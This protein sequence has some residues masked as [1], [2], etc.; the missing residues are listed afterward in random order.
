MTKK[1]TLL[2]ISL[3][4]VFIISG[5]G[6]NTRVLTCSGVTPGTNM[7]AVSNYEAIFKNNELSIIKSKVVFKDIT[8]DNLSSVWD[9]FKTQFNDQ[10]K[11]VEEAGF[12]RTTEADDKNYTFTVNIEIDFD[13]ISKETMKKYD[14]TDYGSKTYD[15]IKKEITSDGVTSCK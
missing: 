2:I 5:C 6:N 3:F 9:T 7:N 15:E 11:P 14:I 4:V 10:N 13:K 8:V 1:I 12:K